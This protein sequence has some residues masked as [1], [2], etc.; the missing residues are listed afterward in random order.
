FF[1]ACYFFFFSSIRRHTS[2]SRD[3]CSDVCS[4][5]LTRSSSRRSLGAQLR[6]RLLRRDERS[7]AAHSHAQIGAARPSGQA[8]S[9][10]TTRSPSSRHL[11]IS[12]TLATESSYRPR[13]FERVEPRTQNEACRVRR[14]NEHRRSSNPRR[15]HSRGG[16]PLHQAASSDTGPPRPAFLTCA[17]TSS[18][19]SR[20]AR[21]GA[22]PTHQGA[23][24]RCPISNN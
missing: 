14:R 7:S 4:S 3:W 22:P 2:F 5:D 21:S 9:R 20:A 23:A 13:R 8:A 24:R 15:L 19:Q 18:A 10:H 17:R 6:I 16:E 1:V 12:A 11:L